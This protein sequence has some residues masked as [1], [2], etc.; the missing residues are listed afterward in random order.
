MFTADDA[1]DASADTPCASPLAPPP[2]SLCDLPA[3]LDLRSHPHDGDDGG[4]GG[5]GGGG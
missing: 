5:G 2:L 1:G 3:N 4:G